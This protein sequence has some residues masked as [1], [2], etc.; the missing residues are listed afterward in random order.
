MPHS[1][2]GRA[3]QVDLGPAFQWLRA[4][5]LAAFEARLEKATAVPDIDAAR[6]RRAA[7]EAAM[8]ELKVEERKRTLVDR[9]EMERA[10]SNH[11]LSA[12]ARLL[13][14]PDHARVQGLPVE[15]CA[16]FGRLIR[17]AL[18]ALAGEDAEA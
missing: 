2:K 16:T 13:S 17:G 15:A 12:R 9:A 6:T 3:I 4:R 1:K 14:L 11:L 8:A 10:W 5:D 18:Q 7:A